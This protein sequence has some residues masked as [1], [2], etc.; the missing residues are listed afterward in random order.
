MNVS[1]LIVE[2]LKRCGVKY[3]FGYQGGSVTHIIDAISRCEGIDYIQNYHE[4]GSAFSA[5]AYARVSSEGLGV[6]IATNG[7][8]ATNLITGMANAYCDSIPVLFLTGQVHTWMMKGNSACRQ[9]SFQEIDIISLANSVTKYCVTIK[10]A[11]DVM[12]CLMHAVKLA[13]SGR[14]G[15]VLLDIPIDIQ[16]AEIDEQVIDWNSVE[17]REAG[18]EDNKD[19]AL[20]L[21]AEESFK[22]LESCQRPLFLCGG[23]L[24]FDAKKYVEFLAKRCN[25]PIVCSLMGLDR[26]PHELD[27][28][29]GF[30]GVYGNRYA[31]KAIQEC[32]LLIVIGS[33]LD[34]RITGKNIEDFAKNAKVIHIDI[35]KTELR[36]K[37]SE[38][39][40]INCDAASYLMQ[41]SERVNLAEKFDF[42]SWL[43]RVLEIKGM[44]PADKEKRDKGINPVSFFASLGNVLPQNSIVSADVGQNQ[45]WVAQGLRVYNKEFRLLNSGGL[46]AMGYALPASVG[47][48]F[49]RQSD[50]IIAIM[51]DGGMQMNIQELNLISKSRLPICIFV[52][53]NHSLG[54]IR[55]LQ[56][57][58]YKQNYEGTIKGFFPAP[59]E[60]I[61]EAYHI[62]YKRISYLVSEQELEDLLHED[63]ALIIEVNIPPETYIAPEL[64]GM[65]PIDA[66]DPKS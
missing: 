46:G 3:V 60:G 49:A 41:L 57:K 56:E 9:N 24:N 58:Y 11:K 40:S 51:G 45:M 26:F 39:Q 10:D 7:P 15:P 36:H 20:S 55:D 30:I 27:Q 5:D 2:C 34:Q 31:N 59:I 23:G 44:Y 48:Y 62:K 43:N 54:M 14:K 32:D 52:I 66:Q 47:A 17:C 12:P 13:K 6:A 37:I 16:M 50:K 65:N 28:F 8:G 29:I 42:S 61:A 53:N 63:S 21:M 64:L 25:I 1:E 33:R 38:D 22:R 18:D 35:D 4:Q 19:V